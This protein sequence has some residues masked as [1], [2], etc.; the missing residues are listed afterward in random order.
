ML[1]IDSRGELVN[2]WNFGDLEEL[3]REFEL[4][5]APTVDR[6]VEDAVE[7]LDV[8]CSLTQ[9]SEVSDLGV[10]SI[11]GTAL[12][13]EVSEVLL[14]APVCIGKGSPLSLSV[15]GLGVTA[16][17]TACHYNDL[18]EDICFAAGEQIRNSR[19]SSWEIQVEEEDMPELEDDCL[20]E[21]VYVSSNKWV[22]D[23][24]NGEFIDM[25]DL[26]PGDVSPLDSSGNHVLQERLL[27][28]EAFCRHY[29][30]LF[31]ICRA[32]Q[33]PD[34]TSSDLLTHLLLHAFDG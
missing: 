34:S 21:P 27:V 2:I 19:G 9:G 25:P 32:V 28:N 24:L 31:L 6:G 22:E 14:E 23:D 13:S 11:D 17:K 15:H 4:P 3:L 1:R 5:E 33:I 10:E 26:E 8:H 20:L 16:V 30:M 7:V 29:L 12:V 18:T